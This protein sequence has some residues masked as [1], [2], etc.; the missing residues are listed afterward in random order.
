MKYS[1]VFDVWI[2]VREIPWYSRLFDPCIGKDR[3]IDRSK[4]FF[5]PLWFILFLSYDIFN[6]F[7]QFSYG[8]WIFFRFFLLFWDMET[9]VW[10]SYSFLLSCCILSYLILFYSSRFKFYFGCLIQI[11]NTERTSVYY[12]KWTMK[13]PIIIPFLRSVNSPPTF[14]HDSSNSYICINYLYY[15]SRN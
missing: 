4:F 9:E 12:F 11:Y 6:N 13:F 8:I 2:E 14:L 15:S 5:C 1:Y 3:F 7:L 10:K